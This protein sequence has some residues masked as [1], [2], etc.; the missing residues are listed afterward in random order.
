MIDLSKVS[1]ERIIEIAKEVINE[2]FE[3]WLYI[4]TNGKQGKAPGEKK[5]PR[6]RYP[7][8]DDIQDFSIAVRYCAT[9]LDRMFIPTIPTLFGMNREIKYNVFSFVDSRFP[10]QVLNMNELNWES[11]DYMVG[12]RAQYISVAPIA[13]YVECYD[14]NT[15]TYM[16]KDGIRNAI[17]VVKKIFKDKFPQFSVIITEH[18]ERYLPKDLIKDCRR[19]LIDTTKHKNPK[20]YERQNV[21][22]ILKG[23]ASLADVVY[24]DKGIKIS[25]DDKGIYVSV[26]DYNGQG[27]KKFSFD[28]K[29]KRWKMKRGGGI[30]V[31]DDKESAL[32]IA[33]VISIEMDIPL[34]DLIAT[35]YKG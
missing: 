32:A 20:Q 19:P 8:N 28:K 11:T 21:Y 10:T 14:K 25:E 5:T 7:S 4:E 1:D 33:K 22:V 2:S 6:F 24:D 30:P 35:H 15:T 23:I 13:V 12:L 31:F 27:P 29:E 26:E 17:D 3:D 18:G 16:V 9:Q 34:P